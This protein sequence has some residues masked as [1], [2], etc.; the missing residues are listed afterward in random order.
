MQSHSFANY[1]TYK[2]AALKS[3]ELHYCI[4]LQQGSLADV[5][6][7]IFVSYLCVTVLFVVLESNLSVE[8]KLLSI[9]LF[10]IMQAITHAQ[11]RERTQA[12]GHLRICL[13]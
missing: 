1:E 5:P 11:S 13:L 3:I 9:S 4:A 6:H 12:H 8:N 7:Y 10:L 2:C